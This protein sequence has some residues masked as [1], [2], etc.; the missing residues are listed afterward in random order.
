MIARDLILGFLLALVMVPL[1]IA[2]TLTVSQSGADSGTVIKG[3]TFTITVSD[4]SGSGTVNL[5]DTPSGF[6]SEE[7]TSKSFSEGTSS[8]TWTTAKIS[9]IQNNIRMKASISVAGSPSTAES[10][11]FNIVLPPSISLEVTPST[12]SVDED[13]TYTVTLNIQNS[14]GTS[15]KSVAFS[16]SGTGM[17]IYSGCSSV[18]S[19]SA[20]G[21]TSVICKIK[22][23]TA[24]NSIPVTFTAAP[25][26]CESKT[27]SM[28]VTV[29]ASGGTTDEGPGGSASGAFGGSSYWTETLIVNDTAFAAGYSKVLSEKQRIKVMISGE[30]HYV[31]VI[32][33][34]TT[35]AVI[36]V[37]S[38]SQQATF[39]VGESKMFEVT[40]DS[41]YD[42]SVKLNSITNKTADVTVKQI[43]EKIVSPA[44]QNGGVQTPNVPEGESGPDLVCTSGSRRCSGSELQECSNGKWLTMKLCSNGC[45]PQTLSCNPKSGEEAAVGGANPGGNNSYLLILLVFIVLALIALFMRRRA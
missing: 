38:T 37:S 26:N 35:W 12:A 21:S 15:A 28:T 7:G 5:I 9:Q 13:S 30:P 24:G 43:H 2:A 25:S 44:G 8:V 41:Y 10:E 42:I 33:V 23:S 22:A 11:L 19:I 32:S 29:Q 3:Q 1:S 17:S 27:D 16:V 40:N 45:N 31:G 20:G 18:S 34:N 39:N 4:L 36:N 6:S 14:G